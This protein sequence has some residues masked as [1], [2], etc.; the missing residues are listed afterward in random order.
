MQDARGDQRQ[1]RPTDGSRLAARRNLAPGCRGRARGRRRD[2]RG[3]ARRGHG[4]WC[5]LARDLDGIARD[6]P[7]AAGRQGRDGGSV[8]HQQ[9]ARPQ[10]GGGGGR[11]DPGGGSRHPRRATPL[12]RRRDPRGAFGVL[13]GAAALRDPLASPSL[14]V[15]NAAIA[16]LAGLIALFGLL[17]LAGQPGS[18]CGRRDRDR[19]ECGRVD[20]PALPDRERRDA[21]RRDRGWRGGPLPHRRGARGRDRGARRRSRH[22]S[23][24]CR[25]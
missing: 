17:S 23:S 24:P 14:A 11:A 3:R 13:A 18:S 1:V 12:A 10:R 5:A 22:R 15:V 9:Q 4:R 6:Q 25:R 8:R 20:P 16:V 21:G 2:R 7:A 19:L